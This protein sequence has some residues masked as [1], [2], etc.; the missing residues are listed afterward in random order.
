MYQSYDSK[1]Y[2]KKRYNSIAN[3][4]MKKITEDKN[5]LPNIK[6]NSSLQMSR[7]NE[8]S[9][10]L[11]ALKGVRKSKDLNVTFD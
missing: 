7:N 10:S 6:M 9:S 3:E 8:N 2:N 4:D 5:I 1:Q 11:T